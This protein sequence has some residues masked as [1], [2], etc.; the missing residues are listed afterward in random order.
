MIGAMWHAMNAGMLALVL[1]TQTVQTACPN[2]DPSTPPAGDVITT[3]DGVGFR[4]ETVL[5][6]LEVPWS[7]TFAPDGRLF[8]TE[9]PGRV[10]IATPGSSSTE[11]ALT[12]DG[13][14]SQGEGGL[15]GLAL[16]PGFSQNRF[17]YLY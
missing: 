3:R 1:A 17:V 5:T 7:L 8:V 4:V 16:D 2:D 11:L 14:F 6:G 15:L 12:L 9:R 13:V 10:R